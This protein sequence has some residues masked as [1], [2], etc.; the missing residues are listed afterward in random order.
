MTASWPSQTARQLG[1]IEAARWP[2]G[3]SAR[4]PA[5]PDD[6]ARWLRVAVVDDDPDHRQLVR[7]YAESLSEWSI[8][9]MEFPDGDQ[10]LSALL[11][12]PVDVVLLDFHLGEASGLEVLTQ[13]RQAGYG[14][15][16]VI[17]SGT[18]APR[19]AHELWRAGADD[20]L[21]KADLQPDTLARSLR[22]VLGR[23]HAE[24]QVDAAHLA[25]AES[26]DHLA[27]VLDS[28]RIGVLAVDAQGVTQFVNRWATSVFG[29]DASATIGRRWT[30]SWA[31]EPADRAE[32]AAMLARPAAQ[33]ERLTV[34]FA[35]VGGARRQVDLEIL[36]QPGRTGGAI[37]CAYDMT[38]IA[39]LKQALRDRQR[40]GALVGSSEPMIK[41]LQLVRDLAAMDTTV[42]IEGETGTGKELVARALHEHSTRSRGP[43]IAVNCGGLA[44]PLLSSLLFGHRRGAFTGAQADQKGL[45][46]AADGGTLLLDEV[47]EVTPA[48]QVALLRVLQ[49]R[50]ITRLGDTVPRK[51]DVRVLA[52]THR[53]LPDLV[54]QGLFRQDLLYRL[55]VARILVPPLRERR[56]DIPGLVEAFLT[57]AAA[58]TGRV[59]HSVDA[60]AL[61]RLLAHDW[62]G[63]VREL[64]SAVEYAVIHSQRGVIAAS[65]LPPEVGQ[66]PLPGQIVE[67][68][69]LE[70]PDLRRA[71]LAARGNRARA[72]RLLGIGRATFYRRL[73]ELGL[74][75]QEVLEVVP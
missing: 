19:T 29:F 26:R 35:A 23:W 42:L 13:L 10:A 32:L 50:E 21:E 61:Q 56:T 66:L 5:R 28:L 6:P 44:E 62:P 38:E 22:H 60:N 41:V 74:T 47:G 17:L 65:D 52:A 63:N 31:V 72:A 37:V 33:R 34:R 39:D 20:Y 4:S 49:E 2:F 1:P 8:E 57:T 64:K 68:A 9:V 71:L 27:A 36:D 11:A 58:S 30:E 53:H 70:L 73:A 46:E 55:R 12:D 48:L 7:L 18:A 16:V 40:F 14:R 75:P 3:G 43:F 59:V 51:I 69:P 67:G 25:L 45:L 24:Q 54:Q 15:P